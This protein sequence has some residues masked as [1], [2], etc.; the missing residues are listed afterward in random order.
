MSKKKNANTQAMRQSRAQIDRNALLRFER[1][2]E[3]LVGAGYFEKFSALCRQ[4]LLRSRYDA[5]KMKMNGG[6]FQDGDGM[7]CREIFIEQLNKM[8]FITAVGEEMP[9]SLYTP[10]FIFAN[11]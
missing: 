8:S 3:Y 9:L 6:G 4:R 1:A 2:C 10:R 11:I 7:I 5:V